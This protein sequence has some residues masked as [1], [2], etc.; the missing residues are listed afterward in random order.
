MGSCTVR[1]PNSSPSRTCTDS[2]T[3]LLRSGFTIATSAT[4]GLVDRVR[5]HVPDVVRARAG[6]A[7]PA[8]A[9]RIT[10][11]GWIAVVETKF[12]SWLR[13]PGTPRSQIEP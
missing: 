4:D 8:T 10:T 13:Q 6:M 12:V 5:G 9:P 7:A 3:A 2:Y 11:R 1:S